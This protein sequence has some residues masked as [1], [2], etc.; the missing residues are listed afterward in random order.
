MDAT[1]CLVTAD[2][3]PDTREPM[4]YQYEHYDEQDQH[5]GTVL[6]VVVEF[7]GDTTQPQQTDNLQRRE[8]ATYVLYAHDTGHM[9]PVL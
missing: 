5:G 1:G 9:S 6:E 2:S 4:R 3:E 7:T 8:Q